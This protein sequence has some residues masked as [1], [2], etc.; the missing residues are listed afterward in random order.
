MMGQAS[1]I[2]TRVLFSG[3]GRRTP[4]V[5]S[6]MVDAGGG[7]AE[8]Q[9]SLRFY[10]TR[11]GQELWQAGTGGGGR[12]LTLPEFANALQS[13]ASMGM[14][15]A[16]ALD[17]A[18]AHA[19]LVMMRMAV[20]PIGNRWTGKRFGNS[21]QRISLWNAP[22]PRQRRSSICRTPWRCRWSLT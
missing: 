15:M 9:S 4:R 12:E 20:N 3:D 1:Q 2:K 7:R 6:A 21:G 8:M 10:D 19:A 18:G 11:S 14:A 17:D 5:S 13:G 22:D 16:L